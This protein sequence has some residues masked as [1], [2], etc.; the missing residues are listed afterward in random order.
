MADTTDMSD[1]SDEINALD[2][3][4]FRQN[5]R[6]HFS[7][8]A[9]NIFTPQ[10]S[11]HY[12]FS[13][14]YDDMWSSWWKGY[15]DFELERQERGVPRFEGQDALES[16]RQ[17][18]DE[19][20]VTYYQPLD[21]ISSSRSPLSFFVYGQNCRKFREK[22]WAATL[23]T[24]Q[25]FNESWES[26][27]RQTFSEDQ[28]TSFQ[29]LKEWW[30]ASYAPLR[31]MEACRSLLTTLSQKTSSLVPTEH[32]LAE[33]GFTSHSHYHS[34]CLE[35]FLLEFH[36]YEYEPYWSVSGM[37]R[38]QAVREEAAD[39]AL[40]MRHAFATKHQDTSTP[41]ATYTNASRLWDTWNNNMLL[42]E[43][44][45]SKYDTSP[46]AYLW[47][48]GMKKT[49]RVSSDVVCPEYSCVT[50]TWGRMVKEP[51]SYTQVPGVPWENLELT[52]YDVK[53]VPEMLTKLEAEYI[54]I[55]LFCI[56]QDGSEPEVKNAEIVKQASIFR[57]SKT[58]IAWLNDVPAWTGTAAG[59]RY[60]SL[61]YLR[62]TCSDPDLIVDDNELK[63][64][65]A[66]ASSMQSELLLPHE[67][68][69]PVKWFSSLWTLQELALCPNMLLC[70][71][72]MELLRDPRQTPIHMS[73]LFKITNAAQ[74]RQLTAANL[75][76]PNREATAPYQLPRAAA[77]LSF[78]GSKCRI[79]TEPFYR[80]PIELFMACNQRVC[81]KPRRRAEAIMSALDATDWYRQEFELDPP[82]V[83]NLPEKPTRWPHFTMASN[84]TRTDDSNTALLVLGTFRLAFVREVAT[85]I[86]SPFFST[87]STSNRLRL[88]SI[89][90]I[91]P[92]SRIASQATAGIG[93]MMPFQKNPGWHCKVYSLFGPL[94]K[95]A[96]HHES[97]GSWHITSNGSVTIKRVGILASSQ[98]AK[99]CFGT[100]EAVLTIMNPVEELQTSNQLASTVYEGILRDKLQEIAGKKSIIYAVT[101]YKDVRHQVGVVLQ[102]PKVWLPLAGK[103][104]LVKI[105]VFVAQGAELMPAYTNVDW[106]VL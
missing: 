84:K 98:D 85:K 78:L 92:D 8:A 72:A 74:Q 60:W 71:R 2:N 64:A 103:R 21:S 93:S 70:N 49:V 52:I 76:Q 104:Q 35:L 69:E 79:G 40:H 22:S 62:N 66:V 33:L 28:I 26:T 1:M 80:T 54:W 4:M 3:E 53:D 89:D 15:E 24:W 61:L 65:H 18:H 51:R 9:F 67:N 38:L 17:K 30:N 57:R 105:G 11:Y 10:L 27:L 48:V 99:I 58:C 43:E 13:P 94:T 37:S 31:D 46:P 73:A 82:K 83:H 102:T 34:I 50:H 41:G 19:M 101:L 75:G 36:P 29:T 86:G 44:P 88:S 6:L 68:T 42:R 45:S 96:V 56:P 59:I 97:V 7:I 5:Y 23:E 90:G 47:N 100:S 20:R 87:L 91:V 55:D 77:H 16:W 25:Y 63:E 12:M 81:T 32:G 14:T 106:I 39:A 95:L